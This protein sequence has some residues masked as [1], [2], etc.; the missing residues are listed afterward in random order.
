[1]S[2]FIKNQDFYQNITY[3][4]IKTKQWR[5]TKNIIN[6][7]TTAKMSGEFSNLPFFFFLLLLLPSLSRKSKI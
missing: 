4:S 5:T 3:T 7:A 1:M 6:T 2:R